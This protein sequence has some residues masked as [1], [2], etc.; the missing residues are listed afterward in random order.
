FV[1]KNEQQAEFGQ[2]YSHAAGLDLCLGNRDLEQR[3]QV[4]LG[5]LIRSI[6]KDN[7]S[8]PIY[9]PLKVFDSLIVNYG[10]AFGTGYL[11]IE[12]LPESNNFRIESGTRIGLKD[13]PGLPVPESSTRKEI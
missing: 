5:V 1:H 3:K 2:W 7:E 10:S 4:F 11:R 6:R 8:L 13:K 12:L 9:G